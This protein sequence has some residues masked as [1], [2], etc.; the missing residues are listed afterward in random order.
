M[1]PS[2][3]DE[4]AITQHL[5]R[6]AYTYD[7][8]D[9]EGWVNLFTEDVSTD[10]ILVGD[11]EPFMTMHGHEDLRAFVTAARTP[12]RMRVLHHITGIV[13]DEYAPPIA[14]TRSMVV[15][16]AQLRDP[17]EPQI[18]THGVYH[19]AWR[20]TDDGWRISYRRYVA[21]GYRTPPPGLRERQQRQS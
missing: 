10:G 1:L 20:K 4:F 21:Y 18:L 6:Y 11:D 17:D 2:R 16:T 8:D 12:D 9:A 7:S 14:R 3:E 15:V 13:F 5:Y 19:D